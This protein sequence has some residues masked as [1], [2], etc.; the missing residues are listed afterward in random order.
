MGWNPVIYIQLCVGCWAQTCPHHFLVVGGLESLVVSWLYPA[1]LWFCRLRLIFDFRS[2]VRSVSAVTLLSGEDCC[3]VLRELTA[4]SLMNMLLMNRLLPVRLW[5][6]RETVVTFYTLT[7]FTVFSFLFNPSFWPAQIPSSKEFL[8]T[9][10]G[11][12]VVMCS[13]CCCYHHVPHAPSS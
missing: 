12:P 1:A 5:R 4:V 6:I 2:Y 10:L 9:F 11:R 3:I 8:W 7:L 13:L